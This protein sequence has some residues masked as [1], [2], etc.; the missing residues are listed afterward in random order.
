MDFR[1]GKA[2]V[3]VTLLAAA[4]WWL[5]NDGILRS[6]DC[7]PGAS[8]VHWPLVMPYVQCFCG[9]VSFSQAALNLLLFLA[10]PV[11]VYALWSLAQR[12]KPA[13]TK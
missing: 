1:P 6:C 12:P 9:C 10:A 2:K 5:Y 4:L 3:I 8:C 7:I 11:V 13:Q